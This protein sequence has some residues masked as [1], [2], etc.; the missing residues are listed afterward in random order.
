[1]D[2]IACNRW[3]EVRRRVGAGRVRRQAVNVGVGAAAKGFETVVIVPI[4]DIIDTELE[5]MVGCHLPVQ[6]DAKVGRFGFVIRVRERCIDQVRYDY[7]CR[8]GHPLTK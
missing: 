7:A 5:V 1:M 2:V 6:I 3:R 8:H 4:L